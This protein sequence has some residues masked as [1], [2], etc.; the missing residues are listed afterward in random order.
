MIANDKQSPRLFGAVVGLFAGAVLGGALLAP[1]LYNFILYLGRHF[2]SLESLRDTDFSSVASRTMSILLVVGIYPVFRW[3]GVRSLAAI[4]WGVDRDPS[5]RWPRMRQL[6]LGWGMGCASI[7]CIYTLGVVSGAYKVTNPGD[8]SILGNV[9]G[10]LAG[11][12]LIGFLEETIF[13]GALYG[14]LR[15][16]VGVAGGA[17]IA[18]FLF[19]AV[20]FA[21]PEPFVGVAY[22][23]WYSGLE[24]YSQLFNAVKFD[25]YFFPFCLTLFAMGL[26]LCV[27]YEYFGSLFFAMGLHAGWVWVMKM[28]DY[29]IVKNGDRWSWAFGH[30]EAIA[31][32]YAALGLLLVFLAVGVCLLLRRRRRE[33]GG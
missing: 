22:G 20:H 31:R 2:Q 10:Y 1:H 26:V 8:W 25:V 33:A 29:F 6:L 13:R 15:S 9:L 23:H 28:G 4:G 16:L 18:S 11:G 19:S 24:L 5:P 7:L 27:S 3:S 17:V 32:S 14:G 12:F 30:D 21:D